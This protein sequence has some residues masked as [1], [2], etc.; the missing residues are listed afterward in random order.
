MTN[1]RSRKLE[2]NVYK[3]GLEAITQNWDTETELRVG[4]SSFLIAPLL[5]QEFVYI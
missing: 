3:L 1:G 5:V 2:A 4:V